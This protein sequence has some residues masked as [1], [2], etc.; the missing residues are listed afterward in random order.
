[1]R[2]RHDR[3]QILRYGQLSAALTVDNGEYAKIVDTSD[4]WIRPRTGIV[5]RHIANGETTWRMGARAAR[6]AIDDA[7]IDPAEIGL[8]LVTTVT[9]DFATPSMSCC[10][11]QEIGAKNAMCIDVNC[12]CAAFVYAVDMARRYLA[13]GDG[14]DTVLVVSTEMLSRLT[15]YADRSTCVLFGDGAGRLRDQGGGKRH[16]RRDG[17]RGRLRLRADVLQEPAARLPLDHQPARAG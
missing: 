13:T 17:R 16:V 10:I 9:A 2:R 8:V 11:Q 5:T 7:G 15:N 4:E 3:N 14:V 12:A 6:A 1:M